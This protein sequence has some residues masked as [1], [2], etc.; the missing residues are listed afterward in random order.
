MK[1]PIF[2]RNIS[3]GRVNPFR[4]IYDDEGFRGV[5]KNK[6]RIRPFPYLVDIELTNICNLKCIFCGQQVMKR[7]RGFMSKKV[8][9]K[10]IGECKQFRSPVRFIRWGEPFLHPKII[11][12]ARLAKCEELPVHITT[13]GLVITEGQM[14]EMVNIGVDSLI[15]SFQGAT[16]KESTR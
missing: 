14:K 8:F 3:S 7:P 9:E 2:F 4:R 15:F 12:F 13:N 1:F 10:I 6:K 16:K 5:L 11:E